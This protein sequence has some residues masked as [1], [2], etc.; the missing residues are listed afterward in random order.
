MTY[1]SVSLKSE[2]NTANIIV[3]HCR[4]LSY[5]SVALRSHDKNDYWV[6]KLL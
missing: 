3:Q 4:N 1:D 2:S 6:G 5:D